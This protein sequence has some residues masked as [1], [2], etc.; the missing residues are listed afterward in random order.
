MAAAIQR[1]AELGVIASTLRAQRLRGEPIAIDVLVKAENAADRAVRRLNIE[2]KREPES[3]LPSLGELL[4][5]RDA[6]RAQP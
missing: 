6:A 3:T 4:R 2:H 5:R 1:A